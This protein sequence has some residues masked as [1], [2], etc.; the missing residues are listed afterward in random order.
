LDDFEAS[1]TKSSKA[2]IKLVEPLL[3]NRIGGEFEVVEGVTVKRL[4]QILDVFAGIDIWHFDKEN[5]VRGI[6]S[7]IQFNQYKRWDSFTI[8]KERVST[9]RT[10]FEKLNYAMNND[11][12]YPNLFLQAYIEDENLVSFALAKTRDIIKII[13]EGKEN[14]DFEI[15]KTNTNQLGQSWFYVVYWERMKQLGYDILV[16]KKKEVEQFKLSNYC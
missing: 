12:A 13:N 5:G 8:R 4:A 9:T 16:Y 11:Y 7:R 3:K 2:F 10:E 1:L 6:A 14:E 15:K